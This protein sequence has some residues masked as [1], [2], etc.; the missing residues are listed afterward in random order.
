MLD[1]FR[2]KLV[3]M[4]ESA[5]MA[6]DNI[7]S[8]KVRSFLTLLG[9]MIGVMAK[10]FVHINHS[11]QSNTESGQTALCSSSCVVISSRSIPVSCTGDAR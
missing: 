3:T 6:L 10:V 1:A 9:I 11:F 5:R 2:K 7:R 8:N 4:K